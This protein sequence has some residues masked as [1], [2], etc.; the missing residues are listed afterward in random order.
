MKTW[1]FVVVS[2]K[3]TK[4]DTFISAITFSTSKQATEMSTAV[5]YKI[6]YLYTR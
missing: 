6:I 5:G 2:K 4:F 1:H 3:L